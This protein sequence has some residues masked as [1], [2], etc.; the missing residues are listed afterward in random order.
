MYI[1]THAHLY[2]EYYPEDLEAT[3]RRAL[4]ANVKQVIL[5]C[6]TSKNIPEMIAAKEQ[7]PEY[8]FLLLGLHPTDVK[9]ESYRQELE[10]LKSYLE[11]DRFVGIGETGIDLYWDKETL[12]EQQLALQEQLTWARDYQLPIS[13][14][15]RDAYS[16]AYEILN[17]FRKDHLRGVMHCFSGGIQEAKWAVEYG[18]Y[19]GIGGVVTFKNSK[20]QDIVKEVGLQYLVLETDAPFLAP[21]PFRG[22]RNESAYI[23]YIAE[24]LSEIFGVSTEEVMRITTENARKVFNL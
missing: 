6:V 15:I 21:V 17:S 13:M 24:K 11:D 10:N 16:E 2:R 18:F 9:K 19:L 22:K 20:L 8:L 12:P 7:F 1:D 14:H 4:D 5:P 3:V 23:P